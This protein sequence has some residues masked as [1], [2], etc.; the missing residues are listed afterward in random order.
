MLSISWC[1]SFQAPLF[2]GSLLLW[3]S[4]RPSI[5][6]RNTLNLLFAPLGL[7]FERR[8]SP[9]K[10]VGETK[11]IVWTRVWPQESRECLLC[12]L[13]DTIH[14]CHLDCP[15]PWWLCPP[16]LLRIL[17]TEY[18]SYSSI[19]LSTRDLCCLTRPFTLVVLAWKM[20]VLKARW[21][22]REGKKDRNVYSLLFKVIEHVVKEAN[23]GHKTIPKTSDNRTGRTDKP[24]QTLLYFFVMSVLLRVPSMMMIISDHLDSCPPCFSRD[25]RQHHWVKET[26]YR[27][28]SSQDRNWSERNVSDSESTVK[29]SSPRERQL[30]R[31]LDIILIILFASS[32]SWLHWWLS[33]F[34][35]GMKQ[36]LCI[37]VLYPSVLWVSDFG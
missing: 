2:S 15:V 25:V 32:F 17:I 9:F 4:L 19:I 5:L 30:T 36:I 21:R 11:K 8:S 12:F 7:Q 3:S 18:P 33:W 29:S 34:S 24:A 22:L 37:L 27:A 20:N 31:H 13:Y 23:D 26:G 35:L 16:T 28:L 1:I 6:R 10:K 14:F